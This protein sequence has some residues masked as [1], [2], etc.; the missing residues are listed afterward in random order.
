MKLYIGNL[1]PYK[2]GVTFCD[3]VMIFCEKEKTFQKGKF[4]YNTIF[5]KIKN[6]NIF[7]DRYRR[8]SFDFLSKESN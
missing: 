8:A 3:R 2:K 7:D 6:L 4:F 1:K 5:W